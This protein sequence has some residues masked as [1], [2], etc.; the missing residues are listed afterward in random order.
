MYKLENKTKFGQWVAKIANDYE[1][2]PMEIAD[3]SGIHVRK[4][5]RILNGYSKLTDIDMMWLVECLSDLTKR[6][7]IEMIVEVSKIYFTR[8]D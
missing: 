1:L 2:T 7:R 4:L 6:D 8:N 3:Y 5:S